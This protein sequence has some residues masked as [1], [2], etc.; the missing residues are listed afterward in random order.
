MSTETQVTTDV[1]IR[2]SPGQSTEIPKGPVKATVE[3]LSNEEGS[4][5]FII[6]PPPQTEG[7]IPVPAHGSRPLALGPTGG[8]VTNTGKVQLTIVYFIG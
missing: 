8:K 6:N 3:N 4:L 1:V 7:T 5:Y 2:L